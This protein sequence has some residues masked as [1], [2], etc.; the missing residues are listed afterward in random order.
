[1]EV[2]TIRL[3]P[4]DLKLQSIREKTFLALNKKIEKQTTRIAYLEGSLS[5]R[6]THGGK[7]YRTRQISIKN[8]ISLALDMIKSLESQKS[9]LHFCSLPRHKRSAFVITS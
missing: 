1:M 5:S 7:R 6:T 8:Q 9:E 3:A 4:G 2:R